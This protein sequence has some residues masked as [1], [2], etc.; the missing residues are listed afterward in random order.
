MI[1]II[2]ERSYYQE[3]ST[4]IHLKFLSTQFVKHMM[5]FGFLEDRVG[6]EKVLWWST[7]L[8]LFHSLFLFSYKNG[9]VQPVYCFIVSLHKVA[10]S[11]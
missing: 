2:K 4:W 10:M 8:V 9:R 7:P 1:F 3:L 11:A 6:S 5:E